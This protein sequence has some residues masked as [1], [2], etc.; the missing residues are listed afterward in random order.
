M[1]INLIHDELIRINLSVQNSSEIIS[2]LSESLYQH[3]YVSE[4]F[5][6]AVIEREKIYPTGLPFPIGVAIPHT[7]AVHVNKNA[8]AVGVLS[9]PICF[10]EM[11]SQ[12]V[13]I[14]VRIVC[15]LAIDK[16]ELVVQTLQTLITCF[17]KKS[18]LEGI[19]MASTPTAVTRI[20]KENLL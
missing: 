11:G 14:E 7:D 9:D 16:P 20:F 1:N 19:L 13:E 5:C 10:G 3:G 18:F 2:L 4:S 17:Q 15:V 6:N 12:G 8:I